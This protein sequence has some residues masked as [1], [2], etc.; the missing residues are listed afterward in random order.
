M[1]KFITSNYEQIDIESI[2]LINENIELYDIEVEEDHTF[3]I[4]DLNLISHNC[5]T[6][7]KSLTIPALKSNTSIIVINHCYS[8]PSSMFPS[9]IMNQSGGAGLQ[10]MSRITIQCS[11][12]LSKNEDKEEDSAAFK[13]TMIKFFTIKNSIVKA[14]YTA[15][16]FIDFNLGIKKYEGL[17]EESE[18]GGFIQ[19]PTQGYYVVPS[20]SDKKMRR[21]EIENNEEIWKTFLDKFNEWSKSEMQYSSVEME[22]LEKEESK[23]EEIIE[24]IQ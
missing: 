10:Y 4:T 7:M 23:N 24:E 9:K 17:F 16:M 21:S 15:N 2:E 20:Y 6:L 3:C 14:F 12:L 22:Q 8:D 13:G 11:K 5:N 1:E 19:C 18:R